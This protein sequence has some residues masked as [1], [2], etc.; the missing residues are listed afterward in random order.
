M[1]IGFRGCFLESEAF[2]CALVWGQCLILVGPVPSGPLICT[3]LLV[4][5]LYGFQ[6]QGSIPRLLVWTIDRAVNL[7]DRS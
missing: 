2:P 6:V 5:L 4:A 1:E 3:C 7:V